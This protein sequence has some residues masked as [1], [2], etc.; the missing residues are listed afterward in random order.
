MKEMKSS[1]SKVSR[2]WEWKD[3]VNVKV[4]SCIGGEV[5]IHRRFVREAMETGKPLRIT[6]STP[7]VIQVMVIEKPYEIGD[8]VNGTTY[9]RYQWNPE[10]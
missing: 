1:R 6:L 4:R 8:R 7:K 3:Y 10:E 9:I 2:K 5:N